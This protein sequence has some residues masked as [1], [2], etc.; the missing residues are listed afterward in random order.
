MTAACRMISLIPDLVRPY[1]GA[2][3]TVGQ[4][5]CNPNVSNV[6]PNKVNF[7]IDIRSAN[8]ADRLSLTED[9]RT[10]INRESILTS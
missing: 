1:A 6:I 2:V 7:T 9:I 10:M 5:S 8:D 4:I 3:A